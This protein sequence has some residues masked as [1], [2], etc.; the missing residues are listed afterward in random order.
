MEA[1]RQFLLTVHDALHAGSSIPLGAG[2]IPVLVLR[3]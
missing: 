3:T 1:A 2:P